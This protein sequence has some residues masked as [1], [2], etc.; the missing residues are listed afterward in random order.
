LDF[1][2]TRSEHHSEAYE[3]QTRFYLYIAKEIIS[4]LVGAELFYL[5][6]GISIKV[7][8]NNEAVSDF[9]ND[10]LRRI[11]CFQEAIRRI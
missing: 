4:P 10:L 11:E 2:F 1:K 3:F 6:D 7:Q 9:E 8:L 5:K